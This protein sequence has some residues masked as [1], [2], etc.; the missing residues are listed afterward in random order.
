VESI[1]QQ[2]I[3]GT[4]SAETIVTADSRVHWTCES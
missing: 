2:T 1:L 3:S 4:V